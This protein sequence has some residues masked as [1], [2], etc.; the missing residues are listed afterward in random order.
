M[1]AQ[2]HLTLC[3]PMDYSPTGFSYPWNFPVK[4]TGVGCRFLLRGSFQNRDQ[5]CVSCISYTGRQTLYY[6]CHINKYTYIIWGFPGSSAG[7]ESACS[8]GDPGL[9]SR[10]GRSAERIGSCVSCNGRQILYH[11]VQFSC[12]VMSSS[13]R[14]H[15]S[16][17]T[18]H[19][20]PSP[21][22]RVH[23]NSHP[24]SP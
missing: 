12:S 6:L 17:H 20:C 19:P 5:T 3:N 16:Q 21:T 23:S 14:P 4:N 1:C 22:P 13:L 2:S 8:A 11:S 18:R 24:S 10:S 7:K 9:I 15:E